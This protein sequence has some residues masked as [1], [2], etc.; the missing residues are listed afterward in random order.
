MPALAV[1]LAIGGPARAEGD[2]NRELAE[3]ARDI[4]ELLDG[5]NQDTI[6]VGDF[7]GPARAAASGGAGI[8]NALIEQLKR[9][10]VRIHFRAALEVK[11]DYFDADDKATGLLSLVLKARVLDRTGKEVTQLQRQ[12]FHVADMG[13]MLGLNVVLPQGLD[14]KAR[15]DALRRGADGKARPAGAGARVAAGAGSPYAVEVR[16][17][18]GAGYEPRPARVE[19]GLAFVP[20]R[21]GEVYAV[22]L[23]NDS[24]HEAAVTLTID[25]LSVFA[26]SRVKDPRTGR[27]RYSHFVVPARQGGDRA[28]RRSTAGTSRTP[29]PTR[30]SRS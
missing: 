29:A 26:F 2:L 30:P 8:K 11:G 27:P 18:S 12:L 23:V 13:A 22:K 10:G 6:A 17:K 28:R 20:I 19:D 1:L 4:K 25:G 14:E 3:V 21:R 16:V 7:S 24:P 9:Q 15:D 5:R